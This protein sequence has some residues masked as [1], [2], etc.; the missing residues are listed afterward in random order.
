MATAKKAPA[1]PKKVA[2][3]QV[4]ETP[5]VSKKQEPMEDHEKYKDIKNKYDKYFSEKPGK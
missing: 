5:V 3:E 2:V 1:K 4:I